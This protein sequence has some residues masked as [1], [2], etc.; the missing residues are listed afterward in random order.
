VQGAVERHARCLQ[1]RR[2]A[3]QQRRDEAQAEGAGEDAR[4][5]REVEDHGAPLK[6]QPRQGDR[7]E[8]R[9]RPG[10]YHQP[11]GAGG[12]RD[13]Q[14]FEQQLA[15]E[16][17]TRCADGEP[18]GDLPLARHGTREQQVGDVGGSDREQQSRH[19]HHEDAHGQRIAVDGKK[20][21]R[22]G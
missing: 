2:Q 14:A 10:G 9:E 16:P 12:K 11:A 20:V 3:D 13:A 1:R 18:D 6:R 4:V 22:R 17:C 19:Q 5:R 15:D 8:R 7:R 21:A